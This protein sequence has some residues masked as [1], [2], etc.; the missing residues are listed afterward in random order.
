M[1]HHLIR[2]AKT[3][4]SHAETSVFYENSTKMKMVKMLDKD[5][6]AARQDAQNK[7]LQFVKTYKYTVYLAKMAEMKGCGPLLF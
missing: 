6:K 3:D 1:V 4:V 7:Y 2:S 5:A